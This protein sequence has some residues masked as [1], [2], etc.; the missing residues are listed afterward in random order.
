MELR[1]RELAFRYTLPRKLCTTWQHETAN[2]CIVCG[3]CNKDREYVEFNAG[4]FRG[5]FHLLINC[6]AYIGHLQGA[7]KVYSMCRLLVN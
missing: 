5:D 3:D 2:W 6:A 7:S 1:R 4:L